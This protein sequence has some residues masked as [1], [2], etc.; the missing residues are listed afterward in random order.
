M[1]S[2]AMS[3]TFTCQAD[4][5]DIVVSVL[6]RHKTDDY[7]AYERGEKWYMGLGNQAS[8]VVD[9]EARN[10]TIDTESGRISRPIDGSS[11]SDIVRKFIS[12]NVKVGYKIFGQAGFNYAAHIRG[13]AFRPGNWP[14][15]ALL[16]PRIDILIHQHSVTVKGIDGEEVKA[17]YQS[18]RLD[19]SGPCLVCPQDGFAID[20]R[21]VKGEYSARVEKALSDISQG[22]YTKVIPSRAL[23]IK[24]KINMPAT[25][26]A[27]RRFNTPA[28]TFSLNHGGFQA[29]GFSPELV[30]SLD[31]G[32]VVTEPLAGTRSLKGTKKEVRKLRDELLNDP[33][34]IL[35]HVLSVK[36]A[37]TELQKLCLPD[38]IMV[39]DLMSIRSRGSVQHLGSR[40]AGTLSPGKD[41]WDAFEVLFPSITA[42]GIPK[43]AAIEAIERLE[44]SPRELYSGAVFMIEDP[45]SFEAALVLRTVFQDQNRTWI[46]AGAG[47]IAQSNPQRELTETCEKLASIAPY[48]VT[49]I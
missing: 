10:M 31:N 16:I 7:Y 32:R 26:L 28:R 36:E 17:L 27:G 18:I 30:M 41:M 35:E 37:T 5:L 48:V 45:K 44:D 25:L 13:Q 20:T 11:V 46:Q 33:K 6:A 43:H 14:L 22:L 38:T 39:E 1:S 4:A 24:H 34:E 12:E 40:V 8:L 29:T 23:E 2:H 47:V 21:D 19:T 3:I 42:S 9:S 15:L 49:D